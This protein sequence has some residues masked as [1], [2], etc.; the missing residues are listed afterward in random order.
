MKSKREKMTATGNAERYTSAEIVDATRV[1]LVT[2]DLDPAS[3][4]AANE[5]VRASRFFD[6]ASDGAAAARS[7]A[8]EDGSPSRVF[9]NPPSE[10]QGDVRKWWLKAMHEVA[11]GHVSALAFLCFRIDA[12]QSMALGSARE[13]LPLPHDAWR[14]EPIR[15]LSYRSPDDPEPKNAMH[16]SA[17]FCVGPLDV[18]ARF[19]KA[20]AP[21]GPVLPPR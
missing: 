4:A 1:T 17:I 14:C 21:I 8:R 18:V 9:V 15:R 16:S 2:I 3:C 5:L 20:F 12:V 13:G 7:W 10:G 6:K 11:M 19:R